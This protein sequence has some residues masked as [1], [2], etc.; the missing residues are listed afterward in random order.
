MT[1]TILPIL[2]IA[3]MLASSCNSGE[4]GAATVVKETDSIADLKP[5]EVEIM[6]VNRGV[7]SKEITSN[8]KIMAQQKV[9]LRFQSQAKIKRIYK[10]NGDRVKKGAIIAELDN[11]EIK[12][13]LSQTK[14]R[15][16]RARIDLTDV[17]ISQGYSIQDTTRISKELLEIA[18]IRSGYVQ[19]SADFELAKYDFA[20]SVMESPIDGV[21]ANLQAKEMNYNKTSEPL[22]TV[23]GDNIEASFTVLESELPLIKK[24]QAVAVAPYFNQETKIAGVITEI[25]PMVD[26]NGLVFVKA[27]LQG[28]HEGLFE[29]MNVKITIKSAVENKIVVP[30]SAVTNRSEKKVVFTYKKGMAMWNY[31]QVG[32]ENSGEYTIE[33]VLQEGDT[34]ITKGTLHLGDMVPVVVKK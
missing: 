15:F 24:G 28:T 22:C 5:M 6:K 13:K 20:T 18:K 8:G 33:D 29:G 19:A 32:L 4:K 26:K 14:A 31:V 11:F 30:K 10:V 16:E 25:N 21:L 3:G 9:E 27:L 17:L 23:L 7:F 2:I 34:V 12:I 1:K